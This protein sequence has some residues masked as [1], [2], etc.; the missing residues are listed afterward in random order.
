MEKT[1]YSKNTVIVLE[2]KMLKSKAWLKLTGASTQVFM[3]FRTK[4]K[5]VKPQSKPNKHSGMVIANNGEIVFT[6]DE[7]LEKYG[8]K[9]DR[10]TRALDQLIKYGFIDICFTTN[11]LHKVETLYAISSRWKDWGKS[12]FIVKKRV[13]REHGPGFKKGNELWKLRK[14]T[15]Q[16]KTRIEPCAQ[17]RET[18]V[19]EIKVMRTNTHG[20]KETKLFKFSGDKW[21]D[22]KVA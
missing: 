9:K 12:T 8:I 7:A 3:I 20:E 10:F 17:T 14:Q 5:M 6:Y 21:L 22:K 2:Q 15:Q 4:C 16:V 11:G 13:K 1:R 18:G 19:Y